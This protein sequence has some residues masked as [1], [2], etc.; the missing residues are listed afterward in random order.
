[1]R[2]KTIWITIFSETK[3]KM[4]TRYVKA[5]SAAFVGLLLFSS[6]ANEMTTQPDAQQ[7]TDTLKQYV[8][9]R[10]YQPVITPAA[11][12]RTT[13]THEKGRPI[14]V[15]WSVGDK[16]WV[17]ATDGNFYQS[18]AATFPNPSDHTQANF[19]LPAGHDYG[20]NPEVRYTNTGNPNRVEILH[21]QSQTTIGRFDHLGVSG[22]CGVAIAEGGG[23][24]YHFTLKHKSAFICIYPRIENEA[25]H[26]NVK[27]K[28]LYI[29]E[30]YGE[31]PAGTMDFTDG[32][33]IGKTP[34]PVYSEIE[35]DTHNAPIP[36]AT[37]N[38][39]CFFV[40]ISPKNHSLA[41]GF[42][43]IDPTTNVS[44]TID[45]RPW[46]FV[47]MEEGKVYDYT[48]WLDKD[49]DHYK[50]VY[51]MWDALKSYW[52]APGVVQPTL[53][54]Q[55]GSGAA[56]SP[57]DIRW[58]NQAP[59]PNVATR[60]ASEMP[61]A[62]LMYW[63]VAK[64]EPRYDEFK[65]W[66][67]FGH[68]YTSGTWYLRK[69]VIA[70]KNGHAG[71]EGYLDRFSPDGYDRRNPANVAGSYVIYNEGAGAVQDGAPVTNKEDY[72][73]LPSL[74]Y[75]AGN[76][77]N[78]IGITGTYWT[79]NA[80]GVGYHLTVGKWGV[81]IARV[82]FCSQSLGFPKWKFETRYGY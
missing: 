29:D 28:S 23:G 56:T 74:G 43:I 66:S 37:R 39:T 57:S 11:S 72:F 20:F 77:M 52:D 8:T 6:C 68:L 24:D 48:A 15:N 67:A 17:K 53:R 49:I 18:E 1:M 5:V 13:A 45:N 55:V 33:L 3:N 62:N 9:F 35:L 38:D 7:Q 19:K 75:Y 63:Y 65:P 70:A 78:F 61:N 44:I 34:T 42:R 41:L 73:F 46:W 64:G 22:D 54:D 79:S 69:S 16:I 51:Y 31:L 10:G 71:D 47:N 81:K 27:L 58:F 60:S 80:N 36:S 2:M 14:K 21:N 59:A 12:T 40:A 82:D 76:Q 25:L 26:H 30:M 32:T 4:K 50:P